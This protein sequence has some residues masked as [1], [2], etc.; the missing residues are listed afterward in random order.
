[1]AALGP[2]RNAGSLPGLFLM[3][4]HRGGSYATVTM[5]AGALMTGFTGLTQA[6]DN[7]QLCS[8]V[9]SRAL[10]LFLLFLQEI[11][12]GRHRLRRRNPG[13]PAAWRGNEQR[14]G[15]L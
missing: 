15:S 9:A 14:A 5:V 3:M 6:A 1:M 7:C 8:W 11:I 13:V 2:G 12:S 10:P 4:A